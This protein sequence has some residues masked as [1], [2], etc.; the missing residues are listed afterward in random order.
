MSEHVANHNIEQQGGSEMK[1]T[2][3]IVISVLALTTVTLM[4]S[5]LFESGPGA[6]PRAA[7]H[8]ERER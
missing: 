7:E 3:R 4:A 8:S 6:G 1:R 2:S 5:L